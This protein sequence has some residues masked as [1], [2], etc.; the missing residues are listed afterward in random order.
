MVFVD[1]LTGDRLN[2]FM[3][4][5]VPPAALRAARALKGLTQLDAAAAASVSP[6]S[7]RIAETGIRP[8]DEVNSRLRDYYERADIEFLGTVEIGSGEV[9]GP[10]ARWWDP[11]TRT[12]R[13]SANSDY[14]YCTSAIAFAAARAFEAL[15]M[16]TV[17]ED[18]GVEYR[19]V[20]AAEGGEAISRPDRERLF[21]FYKARGLVLLGRRDTETDR[22][23]GVGVRQV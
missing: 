8:I 16:K 17:S 10:G 4:P 13:V 5:P 9:R 18:A 6:K 3:K 12:P 23:L 20:S 22:Y 14:T 2:R 15:S 7:L 19:V 11:E 21:Q 1:F